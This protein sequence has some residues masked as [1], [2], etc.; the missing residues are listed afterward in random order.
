MRI[1]MLCVGSRGDVQ[2]MVALGVELRR[3][4]HEVLLAVPSDLV[5]FAAGAGLEAVSAGVDAREFLHSAEGQRLLAA[6]DSRRYLTALARK[7]ATVIGDVQ[8]ALIGAAR[9][10]DVIV[11]SRLV[12]DDAAVLAEHAGI[13]LVCLHYAPSR[14][15]RVIA[16][17]FVTVRRLPAA[18]TALTHELAARVHWRAIAGSVNGL[19]AR[20]GLRPVRDPTG[21]RLARAG[22][23]EIQA[24]S[25][26]LVP[27]IEGWDTY[28]PVVGF[29]GLDAATRERIGEHGTGPELDRWLDDG[30]PP[31]YIGFGSMPATDP[32]RLL[33]MIRDLPVRVLAGA[34]WDVPP[35]RNLFVTG[36]LDHDTVLPRCRAAVHHGGAGTTGAA[37]RAG[38]PSLVCAVLG[39]Q[40]FWGSRLRALGA[41]DWVR[42]ADLDERRLRD[43]IDRLLDPA[44]RDAA[45][46]L[47]AR[48]AAE[49]DGAERAAGI[50]VE[51][52]R[53]TC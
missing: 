44:A 13:P 9:G 18:L 16:P 34:S 35:S 53:R 29:L 20:L 21:H 17:Y 27:P 48:L 36:A 38:L 52:A 41:G 40:P 39:D 50:V 22:T 15:N 24:Y 4:G 32:G 33:G 12:E 6:G 1:A 23:T 51:A 43:G 8:D 31:V 28:R 30:D 25:R 10:A 19:R 5:G 26:V 47:A 49:G 45:A 14:P 37:L 42:F 46:G 7:R 11:A 2:P 3:R